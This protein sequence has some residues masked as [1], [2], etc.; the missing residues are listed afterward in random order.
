V[1]RRSITLA[2][3]ES[4]DIELRLP[5]ERPP[6]RVLTRAEDGAPLAG[7][8]VSLLSLD[9]N[10]P[11][12]LSAESD[13][14]GESSLLDAVGI[15]ATLRVQA[16]GYRMFEAELEAVPAQ[17]EV[18]LTR[19]VSVSGRVTQ[20]G[21]REG[22][23]GARLVLLQDGQRRDTSSDENGDYELSGVALGPATL[24]VQHPK[25]SG[26]TWEV[27]IEPSA[28]EG[29][30]VP[31][32]PLDLTEPG[33]ASGTVLDAAG[34]PVRGARVGV[35][36]VPAFVPVAASFPGFVETDAR[37][38]FELRGLEPG[39]VSLSAYAAGVGRGSLDNVVIT[40]GERITDLS[41]RLIPTHT[42][43]EPQ[44]IANVAVTLGERLVGGDLEVVIV[45]VAAQSE[46]ERAGVRQGDV[47]WSV[48]DEGVAD[49]ADA[50]ALLG[51][52]DGSD[53]ILELGRDG[54]ALLVRVRREAVR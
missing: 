48:D 22:V 26:G 10:V 16:P 8:T 5:A 28:R 52:S 47:L 31:L 36:L 4:R 2:P 11:L 27:L 30:A 54:E 33:L 29:Q 25:F 9:P 17:V 43:T 34:E 20:S 53:V 41:I 1:L 50:R 49:M 21:G 44:A 40:S 51:G 32:D 14:R 38:R 46:A 37:G 42:D 13:A 7:A 3:G 12:R 6:L 35:G 39:R 18:S 23:R 19:G 15:P 24:S 45:N